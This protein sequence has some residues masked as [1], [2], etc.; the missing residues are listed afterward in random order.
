MNIRQ[1]GL[2]DMSSV[3][4]IFTEAFAGSLAPLGNVAPRKA[5]EDLFRFLLEMESGQGVFLVAKYQRI[6]G[7]CVVLRDVKRLWVRAITHGYLIRWAYKYLRG[8]YGRRQPLL[9]Y[10]LDKVCFA[11]SPFNYRPGCAQVLSIAVKKEARDKGLGM[12]L[13]ETA[14]HRLVSSGVKEVKLEVRPN[15]IAALTLYTRAGFRRVGTLKDT[16]GLW[17]VMLKAL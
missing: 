13:L 5:I 1:A 17:Y 11:S 6:L 15:N 12:R 3:A 9:A 16:R 14:L 10:I 4:D 8:D 2:D 7:Y